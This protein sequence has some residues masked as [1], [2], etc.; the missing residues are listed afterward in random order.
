MAIMINLPCVS[1][2]LFPKK[3]RHCSDNFV[4]HLLDFIT[5]HLNISQKLDVCM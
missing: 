3:A 2:I 5:T 1:H 4:E